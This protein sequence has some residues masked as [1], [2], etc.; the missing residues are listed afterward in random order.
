MD[1]NYMKRHHSHVGT[2]VKVLQKCYQSGPEVCIHKR[3]EGRYNGKLTTIQPQG[4]RCSLRVP[5]EL[6]FFQIT[7]ITCFAAL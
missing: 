5:S 1:S 2:E 3:L 4:V 6:L 7:E